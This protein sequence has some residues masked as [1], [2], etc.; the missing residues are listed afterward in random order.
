M[1]IQVGKDDVLKNVVL[2]YNLKKFFLTLEFAFT[3]GN[4]QFESVSV[5]Q[6]TAKLTLRELQYG[7]LT[8]MAQITRVFLRTSATEYYKSP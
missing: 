1:Y 5:N 3:G 7:L 4:N 8:N 6:I 2:I